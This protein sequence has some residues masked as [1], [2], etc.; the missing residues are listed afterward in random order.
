MAKIRSPKGIT[1][2]DG[3]MDEL[4]KELLLGLPTFAGLVVLTIVLREMNLRQWAIIERVLENCAE[5]ETRIQELTLSV[6]EMRA[7]APLTDK[8]PHA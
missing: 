6:K 5:L 3:E 2:Q 7:C 8:T 4:F 1:V